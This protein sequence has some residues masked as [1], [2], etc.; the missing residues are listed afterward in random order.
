MVQAGPADSADT[1][2]VAEASVSQSTVNKQVKQ[3]FERFPKVFNSNLGCFTGPPVKLKIKDNVVPKYCKP[4]TLSFTLKAKVEAE[5]ARLERESIISPV[6]T[7]EWGTPIVP[8]IKSNGTI[9]ICGDYK[10]T[11]NP[12]LEIDRHPIPRIED[13]F[14]SLQ[15][16]VKFTKLDLSSA[17]QQLRLDP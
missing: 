14:A 10:T 9:R 3:L 7:C 8:V 2:R 6:N 17:Y 4:R 11:L 5:L 13:L 12:F 1:V 15:G 16:G